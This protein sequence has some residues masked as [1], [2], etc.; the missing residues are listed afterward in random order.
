MRFFRNICTAA[1][2]ICFL[3]AAGTDEFYTKMRQMPPES[4]GTM[5]V[6]GLV[7]L[8]PLALHIARKKLIEYRREKRNAVHR[9]S[10]F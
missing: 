4:V 10:D 1:G 3:G 5:V 2:F 6:W 8:I 9:R 7:L